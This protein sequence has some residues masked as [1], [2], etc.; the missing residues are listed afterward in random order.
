M[1]ELPNRTPA[2]DEVLEDLL[3]ALK[4]GAEHADH[5]GSLMAFIAKCQTEYM[6]LRGVQGTRSNH[7]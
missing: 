7:T 1:T 6:R 4:G 5:R 3:K 2:D